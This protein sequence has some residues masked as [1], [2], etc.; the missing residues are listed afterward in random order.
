LKTLKDE[1]NHYLTNQYGIIPNKKADY[2]RWLDSYKLFHWFID[3]HFIMKNGVFDVIISNPPYVEYSDVR[4]NYKV[5][6]IEN[7]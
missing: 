3:F 4:D 2:D 1:L 6:T 5:G 7:L